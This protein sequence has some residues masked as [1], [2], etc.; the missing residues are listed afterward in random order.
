MDSPLFIALLALELDIERLWMLNIKIDQFRLMH[1]MG[2][3]LP[4]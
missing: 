1:A 4:R 3:G 2:A